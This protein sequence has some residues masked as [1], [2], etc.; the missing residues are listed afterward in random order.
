MKW[1][2]FSISS[3]HFYYQIIKRI[4][5]ENDEKKLKS[6]REEKYKFLYLK[7]KFINIMMSVKWIFHTFI[8]CVHCFKWIPT[9]VQKILVCDFYA[10]KSLK[11]YYI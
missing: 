11:I 6:G 9:L 5:Y 1:S 4:K 10:Y 7:G 2:I 3:W 8:A